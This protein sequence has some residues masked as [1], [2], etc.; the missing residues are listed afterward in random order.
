MSISSPVI[1]IGITASELIAD[2]TLSTSARTVQ[3][4]LFDETITPSPATIF[5]GAVY[6][7]IAGAKTLDLRALRTVAGGSGDGNGLKVQ[8]FYFKNLGANPMTIV[9]GASNGYLIFG[10]SGSVIV[11]AGG[12]L[13]LSLA[14]ASADVSASVK[15]I[16]VSGTG[17]QTFECA[18][19]LG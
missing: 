3:H 4:T 14:D 16:D 15:T 18:V 6:A 9:G 7:L 19:I 11:P 12:A 8:G 5:S 2:D 1:K 13:A 10:T 17:T